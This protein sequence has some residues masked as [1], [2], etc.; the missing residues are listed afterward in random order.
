MLL[1]TEKYRNDFDSKR[2]CTFLTKVEYI[3]KI[4]Q[5]RQI[6]ITI[7]SKIPTIHTTTIDDDLNWIAHHKI[8]II[9]HDSKSNDQGS[10]QHNYGDALPFVTR[11]IASGSS[12]YSFVACFSRFI[13][14]WCC[15]ASLEIYQI[16]IENYW[17]LDPTM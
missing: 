3:T 13:R 7:Q 16:N 1:D 9:F 17:K 8:G 12:W 4:H 6:G 11:G 2:C 5:I 15:C 10:S 14:L